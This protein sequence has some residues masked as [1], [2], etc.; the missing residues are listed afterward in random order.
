MFVLQQHYKENQVVFSML[1]WQ[2]AHA[3][4]NYGAGL[5]DSKAPQTALPHST[6]PAHTGAPVPHQHSTLFISLICLIDRTR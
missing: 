1:I 6:R 5:K 2:S 4:P 3:T